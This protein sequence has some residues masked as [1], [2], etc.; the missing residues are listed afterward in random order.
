MLRS[1]ILVF[2]KGLFQRNSTRPMNATKLS[3][4]S[5]PQ[6]QPLRFIIYSRCNRSYNQDYTMNQFEPEFVIINSMPDLNK[7]MDVTEDTEGY[8]FGRA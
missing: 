2:G 5:T 7:L 8:Y 3:F 1:C 6:W 4:Q